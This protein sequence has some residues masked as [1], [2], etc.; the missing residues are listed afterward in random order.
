MKTLGKIN[1]TEISSQ[2][3]ALIWVLLILL[4]VALLLFPV[5][6]ISEYQPIQAPYLFDN[7]PLFGVLFFVWMLLLIL[8]VFSK[9]DE[10]KK[11][12]WEN[13]AL[14]CV[15]GLVFLGFWSVITPY[16]SFS[17]G[18]YNM[19]HVR[20]LGEEGSIPVG[21]PILVYFDFPGMHLLVSG[22]SQFTGM[23]VFESR[24]LF[25]IF[26]AVLFSALMYILFVKL[27][28]SNRLAF[29]GVLLVIMGSIMLVEKM[30][31]FTPGALGFTL[32]AGFLLMLNRT[33]ST[34]FGTT[35]SDRLLMLIVFIAVTISYFPTSFLAPLILLG[36]FAVQMIGRG[37]EARLSL[38]T[39]ALLLLMVIAWE[40]Y[41]TWH[42]FGSLTRFIP[43]MIEN[44]LAG[45]FVTS[46]KTVGAANIGGALPLWATITRAFWWAM[47]GLS[48]ILGLYNIL[49]V[50]RLSLVD[51]VVTGGLLGVILLTIIGVFGTKGGGQ[52]TKFLMYAPLFSAPILLVFIYKSG[53]WRRWSIALLTILVLA[54]AL[55]TFLSS[56]NL[57][58][59]EAIYSYDCAAGE[60]MEAN[61]LEK[62]ENHIVYGLHW[63][64]VAWSSYYI[65]DA[66]RRRNTAEGWSAEEIWQGVDELVATFKTMSPW[67]TKQKVFVATE[68]ET[69]A[70]QHL[71]G[72]P[73]D[74]PKWEELRELLST[75]N[76]IYDNGHVE[77]YTP[78]Q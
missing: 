67:V 49:R 73:P 70:Y 46:A 52:F 50:R 71:A 23:G 28:K 56:V 24:T 53:V 47:L 57:I 72:I 51:K 32:F 7:L 64:S 8:L 61:S 18:I 44:I 37:K 10:G 69:A 22:L 65:P 6:L 62:G 78:L 16:G 36:I 76:R 30:H 63:E 54:L 21:H 4:S 14:A 33:E 42:T 43:G 60:F 48:T 17:D 39:I 29:L 13:M 77:M 59:T 34:F 55:P 12:T 1:L 5:H 58:R 74:D 40:I 45:E 2:N 26:N 19:G 75:T 35:A 3:R 20:W 11:L 9:P 27:I 41:W 66:L 31:I 25:L 15:F 68:K 38:A